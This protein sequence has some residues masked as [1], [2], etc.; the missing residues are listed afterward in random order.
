MP[1]RLRAMRDK[2]RPRVWLAFGVALAV[3]LSAPWILSS[4]VV[5]DRRAGR[6]LDRARSHLAAGELEAARKELLATLRLRPTNAEARYRLATLELGQGQWE[7]AFLEFQSLTEIHPDDPNGWTGLAGLMLKTGLLG[8]PEAA[9]DKAIAVEPGRADAHFLRGDLR[10]RSGRY[11]GAYRD[12]QAAVAAAGADPAAWGLL[13]R[14]AARAQGVEAGIAAGDRAIAAV[15]K[16]P[17]VMQPLALL[18]AERP[19]AREEGKP[20]GEAGRVLG[21]VPVPAS[22][23]RAEVRSGHGGLVALGREH[24]PGRLAQVRQVLEMRMRQQDWPGAEEVVASARRSYPDT[25]FPSFLAGILE[26]AR[27]NA[28]GAERSLSESLQAAPRSAVVATALAK[29]WSRQKGAAFAGERLMRLAERDKGFAFARYLAA[30]AYMDGRDPILAEAAVRRGIEIQPGSPLPYQQVADYYQEL[31]RPADALAICLKGLERF[32][33]DVDLRLTLAQVDAG[34]GRTK[35]AIGI[36]GEVLSRRPD[37]DLVDYKVAALLAS[38]EE[39]PASLERLREIVQR[40]KSDLPSDPLLLDSLGWAHDRAGFPARARTLL[41]AAVRGAPE[42]P[43][44]HYHLAVVYAREKKTELARSELKA[45][46]DSNRLFPER[47]DAMRLL[48][49]SHE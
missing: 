23:I 6:S 7:L 25:A 22:Q 8:A 49:D 45:A 24:W 32:P 2:L 29:T 12:A 21:P 17:A 47:L 40:L 14:S 20:A 39:D 36:Y 43:G 11:S 34:L 5:T 48:R 4:R 41:E 33:E 10:L 31:D 42:E 13:V 15:G 3:L 35:D 44:P 46:L 37:L 38:E 27:G 1:E 28:E 9:L 30:R 16:D 26:L 19:R 18:L